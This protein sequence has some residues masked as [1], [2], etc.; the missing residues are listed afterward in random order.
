MCKIFLDRV[1]SERKY[2]DNSMDTPE[3]TFLNNL[4]GLCRLVRQRGDLTAARRAI[5]EE[6]RLLALIDDLRAESA[7]PDQATAEA[8]PA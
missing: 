1:R 6:E 4:V 8:V 2:A 7:R 5:D 3:I